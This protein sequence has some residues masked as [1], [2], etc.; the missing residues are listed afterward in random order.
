MPC[1]VPCKMATGARAE[2]RAVESFAFA[3]GRAFGSCSQGHTGSKAARQTTRS[4]TAAALQ[5]DAALQVAESTDLLWL[6]W[7]E[8]TDYW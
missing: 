2:T 6:D 8:L 1:N 4:A 3:K 5:R 7:R